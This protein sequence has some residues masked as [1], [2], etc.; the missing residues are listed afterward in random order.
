MAQNT[1][2]TVCNLCGLSGCGLK[3]MVQDGKVVQVKGD[4]DHPESRG[5]LCPKGQAVMDILYAPDRLKYPLS[6]FSA[7]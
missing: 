7:P 3:I 4:K 2:K 5:V 1:V 6:L